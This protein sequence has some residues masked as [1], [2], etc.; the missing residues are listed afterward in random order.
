MLMLIGPQSAGGGVGGSRP[1]ANVDCGP[2]STSSSAATT[3]TM[4]MCSFQPFVARTRFVFAA[5]F[6][7]G[8]AGRESASSA[9]CAFFVSFCFTS[10]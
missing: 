1:C 7:A 9:A 4:R 10:A 3:V 6:R 5:A 8:T 2:A